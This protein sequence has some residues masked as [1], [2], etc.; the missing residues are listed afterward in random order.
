MFKVNDYY[1]V[2]RILPSSDCIRYTN[3]T[4]PSAKEI[5]EHLFLIP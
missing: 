2:N 4:T 5:N 1:K 3:Q